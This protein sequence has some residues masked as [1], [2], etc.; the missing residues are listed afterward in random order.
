[1]IKGPIGLIKKTISRLKAIYLC[2]KDPAAFARSLGV[3]V[4]E[5]VRFIGLEPNGSQFGSEPYL[6]T[7]GN[8]VT[9][10][11]QVQ[12]VTHDGGMWIFREKQPD[13]NVFGPVIVGDNVFIGFRATI[14]PNVTIGDNVVIGAGSMVVSDIP[15]GVVA[16]GIPA[17]IICTIEEYYAKNK[18]KMEDTHFLSGE[19]KKHY[20]CSKFGA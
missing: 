11:N 1:M 7:I 9:I 15:S 2:K 14:L 6:I 17:K 10:T 16:A 18:A 20:L 4:G 3:S 5:R 12:F 19:D 8:H 13:L